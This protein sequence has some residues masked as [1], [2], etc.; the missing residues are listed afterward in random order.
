ML[1]YLK[2]LEIQVSQL[3]IA[4]ARHIKYNMFLLINLWVNL[5]TKLL[6]SNLLLT[7]HQEFFIGINFQSFVISTA[8]R[9]HRGAGYR[10]YVQRWP[11]IPDPPPPSRCYGVIYRCVPTCLALKYKFCNLKFTSYGSFKTSNKGME[12]WLSGS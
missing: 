11:C 3:I 7:L 10:V 12:R 6:Q 9:I 4:L 2:T 5:R 1:P 8:L